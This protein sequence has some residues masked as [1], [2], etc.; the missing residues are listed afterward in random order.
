M[1]AQ[2]LVIL[3]KI[4]LLKDKNWKVIELSSALFL[5]QSEVSKGLERLVFCGLLDETKKNPSKTS[6]YEYLIHAVKYAFPVK[7]GRLSKG[8][9]TS[10]SAPPLNSK[11]VSESKYVWPHLKGTIKGESIEPLYKGA[12]DAAI[13][14]SDLHEMLSLID[15]LRVGKAREQALAK[16]M[17]KKRIIG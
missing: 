2:D 16:E 11:I 4:I 9:P 8:I 10:H 3:L 12:P 5:S 17:L 15:A 13:A 14:D 7:P 6:F 1:K